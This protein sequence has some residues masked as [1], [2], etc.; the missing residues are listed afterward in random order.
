MFALFV[1][2]VCTPARRGLIRCV[3]A[4][5]VCV[6]VCAH[7]QKLFVAVRFGAQCLLSSCSQFVPLQG[8]GSSGVCVCV[9]V[10]V[11][12]VNDEAPRPRSLHTRDT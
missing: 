4:C 9:C 7:E 1:L 5:F 11:C 8:E 12:H 3:R 2:S 6:C 10:C